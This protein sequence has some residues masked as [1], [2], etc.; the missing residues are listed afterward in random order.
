MKKLS[1]LLLISSIALSLSDNTCYE[2]PDVDEENNDN[3]EDCKGKTSETSDRPFCCLLDYDLH[4][5]NAQ[6]KGT[7]CISLDNDEYEERNE[8]LG[9]LKEYYPNAEGT[10]TCEG[11]SSSGP[12]S[13]SSKPSS[14]KSSSSSTSSKPSSTKS[15]S[16]ST[17]I[18]QAKI[19]L[20]FI[21]LLI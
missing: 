3:L 14:T 5:G 16:S 10:I 19:L 12:S 13:T 4:E 1:L 2:Y 8:A 18:N 9:K 11:D 15:S 17:F 20:S 6:D 7:A 21:L